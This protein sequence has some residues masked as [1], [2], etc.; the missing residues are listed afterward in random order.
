MTKHHATEREE[1]TTNAGS[2]DRRESTGRRATDPLAVSS[3]PV[4]KRARRVGWAVSGAAALYLA[5]GA[6]SRLLGASWAV[7]PIVELGVP[8]YLVAP[9]G[10]ALLGCTIL[11]V[12]PRTAV[13]GAILLTGYLGGATA[14]NV[15][16]EEPLFFFP[17]AISVLLWGGLYLRRRR[18]QTLI[19]LHRS[20]PIGTETGERTP[21]GRL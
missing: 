18:L 21:E 10:V 14:L 8:E 13:L 9:L 15:R 11:Y 16:V 19:P 2:N 3:E 20:E 5:F 12:I 7:D 17:V 1:S 4:S 6:V